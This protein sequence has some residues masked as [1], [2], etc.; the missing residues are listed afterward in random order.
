MTAQTRTTSVL[1]S[2]LVASVL[3]YVNAHAATPDHELLGDVSTQRNRLVRSSSLED[4]ARMHK[5]LIGRVRDR[6]DEA[7]L[8]YNRGDIQ[9][10]ARFF[11]PDA[12]FT[13]VR[14][15]L[16]VRGPK[17][18][19]AFYNQLFNSGTRR[20]NVL[21]RKI[22]RN[23]KNTFVSSGRL[24]LITQMADGSVSKR[25]VSYRTVWSVAGRLPV[26][27]RSVSRSK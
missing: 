27:V 22:V 16:V 5:V 23:G 6:S 14:L 12:T 15:N 4:T 11:A 8:V 3:A 19:V 13:V 7:T 1:F 20:L 17:A 24:Q 10:M 18:I 2:L 9:H 26:I 21:S 25:T